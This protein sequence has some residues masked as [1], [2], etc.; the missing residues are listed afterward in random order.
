MTRMDLFLRKVFLRYLQQQFF[1]CL[2]LEKRDAQEF[3]KKH[4]GFKRSELKLERATLETFTWF[5]TKV[6]KPRLTSSY[7]K[8]ALL[9]DMINELK[10]C[11][12]ELF[13]KLSYSDREKF[14]PKY[15]DDES[16]DSDEN[17]QGP[18]LPLKRK[19]NRF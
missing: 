18:I 7:S 9:M 12:E 4:A 8:Q 3:L 15:L 11:P 10:R 2:W 1:V 6:P 17:N 16:N 14:V 13:S 19:S 5:K